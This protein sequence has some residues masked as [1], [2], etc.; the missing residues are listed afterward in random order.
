MRWVISQTAI[1]KSI[2]ANL[3]ILS[4]SSAAHAFAGFSAQEVP[5]NLLKKRGIRIVVDRAVGV[6]PP[7]FVLLPCWR[8]IA[9][10]GF[11]VWGTVRKLEWHSKVFLLPNGG[12]RGHS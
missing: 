2:W 12:D 7:K 8:G 6:V 3:V 10:C 9:I 5:S 1:S 11:I 4:P